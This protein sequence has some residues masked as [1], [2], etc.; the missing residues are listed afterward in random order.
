MDYFIPLLLSPEV[1]VA[2]GL[3]LAGILG[4]VLLVIDQRTGLQTTLLFREMLH[5]ALQT[6]VANIFER[7]REQYG[8][9]PTVPEVQ[10]ELRRTIKLELAHTN[11]DVAKKF[12]AVSG[13]TLAEVATQYIPGAAT[14]VFTD[15][16]PS[17][18]GPTTH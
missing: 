3:V 4:R 2:V 12:K 10:R 9:E 13:A 15:V 14:P 7:L 6:H 1:A 5:G 11:P 17:Q 8:K 18:S 16:E